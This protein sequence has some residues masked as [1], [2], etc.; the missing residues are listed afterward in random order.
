MLGEGRDE[1]GVVEP[2]AE[3]VSEDFE[4]AVGVERAELGWNWGR[5]WTE[6]LV[7]LLLLLRWVG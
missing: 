3:A 7:E 4:A 5:R 2:E 6:W 1:R